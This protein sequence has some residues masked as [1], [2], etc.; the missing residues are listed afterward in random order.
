MRFIY[1]Y[2]FLA[3]SS[4]FALLIILRHVLQ[5]WEPFDLVSRETTRYCLVCVFY[6]NSHKKRRKNIKSNKNV[7]KTEQKNGVQHEDFP[8]G[9]PS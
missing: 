5:F 7:D 2:V 1:L 8:S 9:H 3:L 6:H 4:P